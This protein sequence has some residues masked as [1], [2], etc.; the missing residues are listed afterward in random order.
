MLVLNLLTNATVKMTQ[1]DIL[2]SHQWLGSHPV[3]EAHLDINHQQSTLRR[4][5]GLIR[6]LR[7]KHGKIILSDVHGYWIPKPGEDVELV[8]AQAMEYLTRI[9]K[10]ARAQAKA[11]KDT[12]LAMKANFNI[13]SEYFEQ[14]PQLKLL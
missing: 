14:D 8:K 5:R 1:I 12:Y 4:I 10:M 13:R 2:E 3:H 9:E 7:I 6:D 11:W